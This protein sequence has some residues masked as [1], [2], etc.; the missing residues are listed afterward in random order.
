MCYLGYN[1]NLWVCTQVTKWNILKRGVDFYK[2]NKEVLFYGVFDNYYVF[3]DATKDIVFGEQTKKC[4][5]VIGSRFIY[6][7]KTYTF[8]YNFSDTQKEVEIDSKII[9]V[10]PK[11]FTKIVF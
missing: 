5:L 6:E 11:E 2:E 8:L 3:D 9:K 1:S 7:G 10:N 4:P